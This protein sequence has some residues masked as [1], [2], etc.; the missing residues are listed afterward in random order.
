MSIPEAVLRFASHLLWPLSC[1]FCG[2]LGESACVI[3]LRRLL[4]PPMPIDLDGLSLSAGGEHDGAMRELVLE[5]K[6][7]SDRVLGVAMGRA[8]G[9]TFPRPDADLLVPVPLHRGS[10]RAFNQSAAIAEGVGGVWGIPVLDGLAWNERRAAQT[11]LGITERQMMPADVLR[12]VKKGISGKR[13]MLVD[14]VATTGTTLL[15]A[16]DA[17]RRGGGLAVSALSWT[18]AQRLKSPRAPSDNRY[19]EKSFSHRGDDNA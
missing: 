17:I 8:L 12:P 9:E 3:C 19:E 16:A 6:Y 1:P 4:D 11:S 15:R 2:A 14:D 13:V 7:G 10:E 5:L 18:H